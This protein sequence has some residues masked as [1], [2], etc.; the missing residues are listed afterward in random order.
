MPSQ[1]TKAE[2]A[3]FNLLTISLTSCCSARWSHSE[4]MR[5]SLLAVSCLVTLVMTRVSSNQGAEDMHAADASR[6]EN[7]AASSTDD[8]IALER[9]SQAPLAGVDWD[10][11]EAD[12]QD[13]CAW[14]PCGD[15][16]SGI[17]RGSVS[18]L[19]CA[20]ALLRSVPLKWPSRCHLF[21]AQF[22]YNEK[23]LM[24]TTSGP[25]IY[26]HLQAE[27]GLMPAQSVRRTCSWP[28]VSTS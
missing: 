13:A 7:H 20:C 28:L 18:T 14:D 1:G 9:G 17:R 11:A 27:S 3:Y 19:A 2:S 21:A 25:R 23:S 22:G 12:W 5:T 15:L 24:E 16:D 6:S 4:H 26:V 10:A 8:P